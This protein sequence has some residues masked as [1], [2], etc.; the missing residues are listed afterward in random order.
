M[1]SFIYQTA[2]DF[3]EEFAKAPLEIWAYTFGIGDNLMFTTIIF[4]N[5][6]YRAGRALWRILIN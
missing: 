2:L 3:N 1:K 5:E 6:L 4:Q